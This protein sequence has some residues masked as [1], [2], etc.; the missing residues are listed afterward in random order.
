M[1]DNTDSKYGFGWILDSDKDYGDVFWHSGGFPGYTT[2]IGRHVTTDKT[3]IIL[4]NLNGVV[5]PSYNI[6]EALYNKPITK[7]YRKEISV[8]PS[9]LDKYVGEYRDKTDEKLIIT[10][11]KPDN[12]LVFNST[13]HKDWELPVYAEKDNYFFS[14]GTSIMMEFSTSD[15]GQQIIKLYQGGKVISEA[16]KVR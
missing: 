5:L 10:I 6:A 16:A 8:E 1:K 14:K 13:N 12:T 7:M 11:S 9:L 15:S 3:I 2:Y 4:Q